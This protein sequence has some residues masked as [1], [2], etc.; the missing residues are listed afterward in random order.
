MTDALLFANCFC[1]L[2]LHAGSLGLCAATVGVVTQELTMREALAVAGQ[3]Q[4]MVSPFA[5]AEAAGMQP[6]VVWR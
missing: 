1:V 2:Q 5:L 6:P 3:Q 4:L